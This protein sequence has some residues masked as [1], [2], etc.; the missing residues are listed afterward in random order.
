MRLVIELVHAKRVAKV[1]TALHVLDNREDVQ[2][3]HVMP[4]GAS[5]HSL[6]ARSPLGHLGYRQRLIYGFR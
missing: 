3:I 6:A 1:Y 2:L 4:Q 5:Q